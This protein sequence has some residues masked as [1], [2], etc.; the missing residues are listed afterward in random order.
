[1]AGNHWTT[2]DFGDKACL[3]V[4]APPPPLLSKSSQP[5]DDDGDDIIGKR[6]RLMLSETTSECCTTSPNP[7]H[8]HVISPFVRGN[9]RTARTPRPCTAGTPRCSESRLVQIDHYWGQTGRW[10]G[11]SWGERLE[12][13]AASSRARQGFRVRCW[14]K[15][16]GRESGWVDRREG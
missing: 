11:L 1:M 16:G 10:R 6:L 14:E 15:A 5:D 7:K 8:Q 4:P 2:S 3:N 13:V 12:R 9:P